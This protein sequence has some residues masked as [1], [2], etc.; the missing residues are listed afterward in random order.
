MDAEKWDIRNRTYRIDLDNIWKWRVVWSM[1]FVENISPS[2]CSCDVETV[3]HHY[4][5]NMEYDI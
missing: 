1:E 4:L 5:E 2:E 3:E